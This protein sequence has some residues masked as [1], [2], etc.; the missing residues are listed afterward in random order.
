[1]S[2]NRLCPPTNCMPGGADCLTPGQ[3][4]LLSRNRL[5]YS[6]PRLRLCQLAIQFIKLVAL[7]EI[8][9]ATNEHAGQHI[10]DHLDG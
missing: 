1:M 3:R 2:Y 9:H 8:I 10:A 6:A 5:A 4:G 7:R